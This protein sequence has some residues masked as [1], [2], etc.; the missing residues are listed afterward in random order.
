MI[1]KL[2]ALTIL[3]GGLGGCNSM[4]PVER[5]MNYRSGYKVELLGFNVKSD[6]AGTPIAVNMEISVENRNSEMGLSVLTLRVRQYAADNSL[7]GEDLLYLP[8]GD[9]KPYQ[10]ERYY[11]VFKKIHGKIA[12]VSVIKAPMDDP[13]VYMKYRELDHLPEK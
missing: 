8:L 11:P 2:I 1:R 6:D 9:L 13:K 10:K 4:T 7:L 5:A 3:I 12:A